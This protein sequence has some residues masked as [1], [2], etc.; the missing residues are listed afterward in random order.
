MEK[1]GMKLLKRLMCLIVLGAMVLSLAACSSAKS[2]TGSK[3]STGAITVTDTAGRE[4]TV[5][6]P[7]ERIV[8]YNSSVCDVLKSFGSEATVI[9]RGDSVP[10]PTPNVDVPTVGKW[11]EP[12]IE[13]IMALKPDAVF[14]Y[15]ANMTAD[16]EKLL[17][18]AGIKCIYL[19]LVDVSKATDEVTALGKLFGKEDK[20][21]AFVDFHDKYAAIIEKKLKNIKT[22]DKATVY[23]E[24]Y[25]D[26]KSVNKTAGGQ[27]LIDAAGGIN[28]AADE[29]AQYPE[30]SDEWVLGKNPD[31]IIKLVSSTKKILGTGITD[32]TAVKDSYT[33]LTGRPS[34]ANLQAV[35]DGKVIILSSE[36]STTALGSIIGELY[37]AKTLY[38]D[39]FKDINVGDVQKELQKTLYGTDL[40]GIFAYPAK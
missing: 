30:I 13:A 21:K 23:Y 22:E 6:K 24:G 4:I 37:I 29:T 7:L 26:Y 15:A 1:K 19:E 10:N 12:N 40:V 33:Q 28:I 2:D 17:E 35:K 25:T 5:D 36:I 14:T 34:W 18:A 20:A 32:D 38:P 39:Q 3:D 8:T 31:A 11:N 9:G 27:A 16:N